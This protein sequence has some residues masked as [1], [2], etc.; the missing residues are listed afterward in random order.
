MSFNDGPVWVAVATRRRHGHGNG[1][2]HRRSSG[3][4]LLYDNEDRIPTGPD[5]SKSD[6]ALRVVACTDG[7]GRRARRTYPDTYP[8]HGVAV[9][10]LR[11]KPICWPAS[12]RAVVDARRDQQRGRDGKNNPMTSPSSRRRQSA[13]L[14]PGPMA[15]RTPFFG[16]DSYI[17]ADFRPTPQ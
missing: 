16:R 8:S 17:Q 14:H 9:V 4:D 3:M 15:W 12:V 10:G 1:R 6:R 7:I 13:Q 11:R 5:P 2:G